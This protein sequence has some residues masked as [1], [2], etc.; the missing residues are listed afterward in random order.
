MTDNT[1]EWFKYLLFEFN[2]TEIREAIAAGKIKPNSTSYSAKR[3]LDQMYPS[4]PEDIYG[5]NDFS[6]RGIEG[7]WLRNPVYYPDAEN[8]PDEVV[9]N[10]PP[11]FV[12][13][14]PDAAMALYKGTEAPAEGITAPVLIDGHHRLT[15]LYVRGDDRMVNCFFIDFEDILPYCYVGGRPIG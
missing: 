11:I 4:T 15:K 14:K 5:S 1:D 7:A 10:E 8:I 9:D 13:W 3:I 12:M 6:D 2:I